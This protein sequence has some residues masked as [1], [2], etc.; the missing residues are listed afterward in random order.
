MQDAEMGG[1]RACAALTGGEM[2]LV[3]CGGAERV[4]AG[5]EPFEAGEGE[6]AVGSQKI[7]DMLGAPGKQVA[8]P[9]GVLRESPQAEKRPEKS[10]CEHL[11]PHSPNP[12]S[13]STNTT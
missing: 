6:P 1:P 7:R 8:L 10:N 13:L 3:V 9:R 12:R 11:A 4:V 2:N 5:L